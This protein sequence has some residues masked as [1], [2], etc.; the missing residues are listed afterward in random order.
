MKRLSMLVMCVIIKLHSQVISKDTFRNNTD[1]LLK[2][3]MK[4]VNMFVVCVVI[5]LHS[6]IILKDI[7][8]YATDNQPGHKVLC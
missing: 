7:F 3:K 5:K 2:Q 8:K 6:Q 1:P 4:R